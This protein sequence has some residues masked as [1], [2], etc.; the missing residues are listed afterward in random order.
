M[1]NSLIFYL[2]SNSKILIDVFFEQMPAYGVLFRCT[3]VPVI[4]SCIPGTFV[5]TFESFGY[6]VTNDNKTQSE[7]VEH[8]NTAI[9]ICVH[10][11]PSKLKLSDADDTTKVDVQ[12]SSTA[13]QTTPDMHQYIQTKELPLGKDGYDVNLSTANCKNNHLLS[14]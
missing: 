11:R 4:Y 5:E 8:N 10:R 1:G 14:L 6:D 3:V 9:K 13:A 12:D 2:H 7:L